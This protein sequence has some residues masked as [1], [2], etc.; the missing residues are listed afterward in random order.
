MNRTEQNFNS[1]VQLHPCFELSSD[2]VSP[3]R[4]KETRKLATNTKQSKN[5]RT[6][7][8]SESDDRISST[9]HRE[10]KLG[11]REYLRLG[12]P[13]DGQIQNKK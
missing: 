11:T 12:A 3:I 1:I 7:R 10:R 6:H 8:E 13:W 5:P 4:K 2:I 9:K